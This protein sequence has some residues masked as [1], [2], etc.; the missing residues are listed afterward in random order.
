MTSPRL[1]IVGVKR[2]KSI[3]VT[4]IVAAIIYYMDVNQDFFNVR[5]HIYEAIAYNE[6]FA[7]H[8]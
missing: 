2:Y 4:F 5:N 8:D 1:W 7:I 6:I 3:V